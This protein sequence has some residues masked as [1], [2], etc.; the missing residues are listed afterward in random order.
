[1]AGSG[2]TRV[3]NPGVGLTDH[4]EQDASNVQWNSGQPNLPRWIPQGQVGLTESPELARSLTYHSTAHK[5]REYKRRNLQAAAALI[6]SLRAK[7]PDLLVGIALDAT[8]T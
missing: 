5:V 1:M 8:L 7:H 2:V 3:A 6:A 4:L